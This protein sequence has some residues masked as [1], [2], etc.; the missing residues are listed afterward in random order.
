MIALIAHTGGDFGDSHSWRA[1]LSMLSAKADDQSLVAINAAGST[2]INDFGGSTRVW[3]ADAIWKW[4]P[5]GNAVRTNFKLQGE[6]LRSTRS[7][8]LVY[9]VAGTGRA[10]TR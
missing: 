4:A 9:D 10:R 8:S 1:G 2:V 6:Y 3:V 7:G 5:H